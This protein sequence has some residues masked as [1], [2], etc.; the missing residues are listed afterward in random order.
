MYCTNVECYIISLCEIEVHLLYIVCPFLIVVHFTR[1]TR[2]ILYT[3]LQKTWVVQSLRLEPTIVKE[4]YLQRLM[5]EVEAKSNF[6][7]QDLLSVGQCQSGTFEIL[8]TQIPSCWTR[9]ELKVDCIMRIN[10]NHVIIP[11]RCI[12]AWSEMFSESNLFIYN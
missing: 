12:I 5:G 3:Y 2:L 1:N 11:Y 4:Q 9:P 7:V 10:V 8:E 6:L